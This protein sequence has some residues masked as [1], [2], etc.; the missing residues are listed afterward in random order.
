MSEND[1]S[2]LVEKIDTVYVTKIQ[3][4]LDGTTAEKCVLSLKGPLKHGA[5]ILDLEELSM[6][7]TSGIK[8]LEEL[9][10]MSF[11]QKNKIIL[12]NLPGPIRSAFAMAGI[13]NLFP[14]APNEEMAFKLASKG[15]R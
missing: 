9:N 15:L 4:I 12:I 13:K 7:T 5:I 14:I 11:L 10:E 3:G 8:A 1:L 6:V 2:V